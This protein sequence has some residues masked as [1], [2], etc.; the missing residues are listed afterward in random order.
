[1]SDPRFSRVS[2]QIL[3]DEGQACIEADGARYTGQVARLPANL[4]RGETL[5]L[6]LCLASSEESTPRAQDVE[7]RGTVEGLAEPS[8]V[9]KGL[10]FELLVGHLSH[11]PS[12]WNLGSVMT[13]DTVVD[14][15][16]EPDRLED[17][18]PS[19]PVRLHPAP[20]LLDEP[21]TMESH[22]HS[23]FAGETYRIGAPLPFKSTDLAALMQGAASD[24]AEASAQV[25]TSS[26]LAVYT[27][28]AEED[29]YVD[30]ADEDEEATASTGA[31]RARGKGDEVTSPRHRRRVSDLSEPSGIMGTLR[32]MTLAELVQSLEFSGKTAGIEVLPKDPSV[33]EGRV[34]LRQ[35][36][37]V[38]VS[39]GE[40]EG[41]EAFFLLSDLQRGSFYIRFGEES[42]RT[43]VDKPTA[44][45]LLEALRRKDEEGRSGAV[46]ASGHD[47]E[48]SG[49][50]VLGD[51]NAA[52]T[53]FG[54]RPRDLE[55][56]VSQEASVAEDAASSSAEYELDDLA[57]EEA[58]V[59]AVEL[60]QRPGSSWQLPVS[61]TA[62]VFAHFFAEAARAGAPV[63]ASPLPVSAEGEEGLLRSAW[64]R[65]TGRGSA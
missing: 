32:Q 37:V 21:F 65:L 48:P 14:G 53:P 43:N 11:R 25:A 52:T 29:R 30:D 38:F 27:L 56:S 5:S 10:A 20:H 13:A 42:P 50:V 26:G 17:S 3:D 35:G 55:D 59:A 7:L 28:P 62:P 49:D 9:R 57:M 63:E 33:S 46:T 39:C 2:V 16:H 60:K 1:M 45:L 51:D 8:P 54:L 64:H 40:L 22:D 41:E 15:A 61:G 31:R 34:Y 19:L 4:R 47:D 18:L 58:L 12:D 36:R 44:Y 24:E 6:K 23:A